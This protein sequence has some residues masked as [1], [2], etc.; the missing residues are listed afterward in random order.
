MS[1]FAGDFDNVN[2]D[3]YYAIDY[4]TNSLYTIDLATG[5]STLVGPVTGM[6]AGQSVAGMAC[7]KSTG[8][9][10]VS[11]TDVVNSDLYTIDLA[12][13]ALTWI[14]TTGIPGLI[15]IAIDGTGMMYGWDI[16]NDQSFTIDK[17]TAAS[18]LLG[19]LG[20]DL[21][22]AQGGNWDP[23]SDVIYVAA[24]AASG[25]LMT[26]D[27]TT[28]AMTLVGAFPTGD[29]VA[30]FGFPGSADNWISINPQS[31][32]IDPSNSSQMTVSFDA[33]DI[34]PGTIKHANI[35]FSS[36][37]AVGSVTVPVTMTV[38]SLDFG[39]I[40]GNIT[41]N[42]IDPYNLGNVEDVLVE[43]GPYYTNPDVNG[44]YS[45]QV[46][47]G[48]YDVTAT[49]Y[50]YTQQMTVEVVVG[51]GAT[52]SGMDFTMPCI[53]G[54]VMG[55]VYDEPSGDPLANA[56][57]K[58]EG[59]EF[60]TT[61]A[62]DGTYE[63]FVEA[64]TYDVT[65]FD[66]T[67]TPLTETD[68]VIPVEGDVTVDFS[69]QP[70]LATVYPMSADYWTGTCTP[71][72]K[73][74]VSYVKSWGSGTADGEN[75]WM[76]FD[77][78][79]MP[80]G[81]VILGVTFHG[82]VTGANFPY[83]SITPMPIDPVSSTAADVWNA[84]STG[85]LQGTAYSYNN[86]ASTFAPGWKEYPLVEGNA[87]DD[88]TNAMNQGWFAV[89]IFERD[90]SNTYYLEFDGWDDANPPYLVID[91]FV[92][93]F[94]VLNGTV[95]EL[96]SGDPVEGAEI[97]AVGPYSTY[98]F[99]TGA[100]GIYEFDPCQT[101]TYNITCD[102]TGYNL[103][104][105]TV[106]VTEGNT[107]TQDF[108]LTIPQ[109]IVD[110]M[111]MSVTVEPNGMADTTLN[112]SNPGNGSLDWNSALV[113]L[114]DET[115]DTWDLQF[116][117][118]L[119]VAS[120]GPGN[121]GAECDGDFFYT[122]R[123]ATNLIHKYDL[124]GN[125]LQEFSIPGVSGLRD[126]AYDGTYFYGGAAA[127]I[128]YQMDFANLTLV[129]SISSPQPVRSIAY[130]DGEN[131]LWVANWATD[132]DLIDMS[133]ATMNVIP[134]AVHGLAG[135]YGTAYDNW[136]SGGP[137]LWIFDQGLGAGTSQPIYQCDLNSITMT[138]FSY[139]VAA[140]FPGIAG[141][142]GGLFTIPNVYSGTVS[143]GGVL[144]G[145]PDMFFMYELAPF[146]TWLT[147][148]PTSGTIAG[149]ENEDM[150]LHFDATD[151]LPGYYN[152]EIHFSSSPDVGSPV[153]PVEMHVEGLI[154]ATNLMLSYNCT[155]VTID[156]DMPGRWYTR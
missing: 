126:L 154:P 62:G 79:G 4:N 65:A 148:T 40:T 124:D 77:I 38:G 42:G 35:N 75:G 44:D 58:V 54:R 87:I 107:T 143:I 17:S 6:T 57:V 98:T 16:V 41:L 113:L 116:S 63:L 14:G 76:K 50:G 89:G 144:Q 81:A 101:G 112:I 32:T 137:Y 103:E 130:D 25:Q 30:A 7:D 109:M 9:M 15:E 43:A 61:T 5:A 136:T 129:S 60:S 92:P 22:Y 31:G 99:T 3:F 84:A 26:L 141:I 86:E 68:V 94:G 82:Y 155:D 72:S 33:G 96:A 45:L 108:A 53:Y 37:P 150:M 74:E 13:G 52:V 133:G 118:D 2:T 18:T 27:K 90:I 142:G 78:S 64:G 127:N 80:T 131:G 147:I 12:S 85:S 20:V 55:T 1:F 152:A 110:P 132:I 28:G 145:T 49:L 115:K 139:D 36:N 56:T 122:T 93:A 119:E 104:T 70:G 23:A 95:T 73:T 29:E 151:M 138:G 91:F 134:A 69:L 140:D 71:T 19:A 66:I 46:Y 120:G 83:W 123:W 111:T 10:Y 48:T 102:A 100:D 8:I 106:E 21:N 121:A 67:H 59:T 24:Y 117:F 105:A 125:L 88:F 39:Y 97:T 11:T 149:G 135:I 51:E 47:P 114:S 34:V 128:I 153:V 146:A 156:W